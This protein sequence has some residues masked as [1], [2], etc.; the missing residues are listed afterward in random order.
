MVETYTL[1]E[2]KNHL[3]TQNN[4]NGE[5]FILIISNYAKLKNCYKICK[6]NEMSYEPINKYICFV[7]ETEHTDDRRAYNG[8]Q[9]SWK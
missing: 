1:H 4:L 3:K 5:R 9:E 7:S 2:D 8:D 6:G